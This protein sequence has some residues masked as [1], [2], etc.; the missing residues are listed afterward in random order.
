MPAPELG[1]AGGMRGI[2]RSADGLAIPGANVTVEG[3]NQFAATDTEG[4][5]ALVNLRPESQLVLV[6]SVPGFEDARLEVVV[7]RGTAG[8]ADFVL[9]L[10]TFSAEVTVRAEMPMLRVSD[11]TSQVTLRPEQVASLPSLGEKDLFRALQLLPGVTGTQEASSGLYVR[12]GTP[13]QNLVTFDAFTL[14]HVDHLFGYFSAFNMDAVDQVEF[15]KTAFKAADGGRLSGVLRLTGKSR[16]G[17]QP[18]GFLNISMLSAGGLLSVP[19]GSRGSFLIAARRSYQSPL[20]NRILGLVDTGSPM[21]RRGPGGASPFG[22]SDPFAS[23][24]SSWFYDL[25]TKFEFKPTQRD[26]ISVSGYDGRDDVDNSRSL[27]LSGFSFPNF[28]G[29]TTT[30]TSGVPTDPVLGISELHGWKNRGYGATWKH[31]WSPAATSTM[32]LGL[33]RYDENRNSSSSLTSKSTGEDFSFSSGRGGSRA[34]TEQNAVKDLTFRIDNAF[35]VGRAHQLSEGIELTTLDV[36]YNAQTAAVA[37]IGP[38]GGPTSGLVGLLNQSGSGR[39]FSGY[40]QDMWN[41][42]ARLIVTPGVRVTKYNITGNTFVEPRLGVNYQLT[43]RLQLKGGYGVYNQVVGRIQYEDLAQGDREFWALADGNHVPVSTSKQAV[44]GA[45]FETS[46]FLVDAELYDK[47]FSGVTLFAPRLTPGV[48]PDAGATYLYYGSGRAQGIEALVQKKFGNNTGW[49]SYT[50]SVVDY[51]Y[52]VLDTASFPAPYDQNYEVKVADSVK[53]GKFWTFGA[54]WMFGSGRPY[55]PAVG[56]ESV[57]LPFG[58]FTIDRITYGA[59]NSGRLPVYH[60]LDLS[61]QGDFQLLGTKSTLGVTVFNLYN[62]QNVWYRS[63]Q[64]FGGTGTVNDVA[65][66]GL[67]VNAFLRVGF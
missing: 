44:A 35:T 60:R 26:S 12:G 16:G 52:P 64:T 37:G 8:S 5:Y 27:D 30:T 40:V 14:Y 46:G 10:A 18:T 49:V 55:T 20:Y 66:M 31:Q 51:L 47:R 65:L 63:Y 33:S 50:Q 23:T 17:S 53:V 3:T 61:T 39:L 41:P 4:R 24:P 43:P 57:K 25:N 59:K 7:P 32:S 42:V 62:R 36:G 45:S 54:T 1:G 38:G 58:D 21:G 2:V 48:I 19:L 22:G 29:Q 11:G 28:P 56:I 15:S 6:A 13:D 34:Q 9:P 67:A